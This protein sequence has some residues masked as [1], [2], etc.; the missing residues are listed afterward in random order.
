[1]GSEGKS[2]FSSPKGHVTY[3]GSDVQVSVSGP[4]DKTDG[5]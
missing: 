2:W 5:N 4:K 1:M 3:V